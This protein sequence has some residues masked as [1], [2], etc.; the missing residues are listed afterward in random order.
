MKETYEVGSGQTITVTIEVND[1]RRSDYPSELDWTAVRAERDGLKE[2]VS[3][4][5]H[6]IADLEKQLA[7]SIDRD[8]EHS[9]CAGRL[10]LRERDANTFQRQ[11]DEFQTKVEHLQSQVKY[12]RDLIADD[13][14][15]S[16]LQIDE[17]ANPL[18]A[19]IKELES[20]NQRLAR[21]VCELEREVSD[22]ALRADRMTQQ[23]RDAAQE[24]TTILSRV[25]DLRDRAD[26][27]EQENAKQSK[28]Y[29]ESLDARQK[30]VAQ[31]RSRVSHA[32]I[33]LSTDA[34]EKARH[35]PLTP[36]ENV[37]SEAIGNAL[38]ALEA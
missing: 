4:R 32:R 28:L 27:M 26:R 13:H 29:R 2:T 34:I 30:L 23:V 8:R 35:T 11:R 5:E 38:A 3:R 15:R 33:A 20:E 17:V 22:E 37:L 31:A 1:S 7:N 12:L 18:R 9:G 16:A 36:N 19:R 14:H 25:A 6:R 24:K 21:Q 10:E